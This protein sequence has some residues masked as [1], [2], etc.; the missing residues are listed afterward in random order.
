[1]DVGKKYILMVARKLRPNL[2]NKFLQIKLKLKEKQN[3]YLYCISERRNVESKNNTKFLFTN[4]AAYSVKFEKQC[5]C[6]KR[7]V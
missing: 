4:Y 7:N 2:R 5:N 1:M 6:S 3:R